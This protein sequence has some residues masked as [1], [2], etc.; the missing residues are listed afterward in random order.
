MND[1]KIIFPH[2]FLVAQR[3]KSGLG[4]AI[5]SFIDHKH[6]HTHTHHTYITHTRARARTPHTHAHTQHTRAHTRT[7]AHTHTHTHTPVT[8]LWTSD[9]P[10][11]ETAT[12]RTHKKYKRRASVPSAGF[13]RMHKIELFAISRSIKKGLCCFLRTS[14]ASTNKGQYI[15]FFLRYK[16]LNI[17]LPSQGVLS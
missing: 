1:V 17:T 4:R 15:F 2:S 11:S 12:H 7:R 13:E 9:Q 14:V 10:V 8:L 3:P 5:L 16:S 6:T